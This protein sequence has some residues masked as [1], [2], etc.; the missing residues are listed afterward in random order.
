MNKVFILF[1]TI[2]FLIFT[3]ATYATYDPKSTPNNI[4]G[5]HI[6]FTYEV[7]KASEL[8][9]SSGGDWGYVTIPIQYDDRDI[10]KWQDFLNSCGNNHVIPILRIATGAYYKNTSVWRKPSNFDILDF[11]NFLNSL[12]W[13][14]KN[15][16]VLLFNETNRFDEWGGE[17][18]SPSEYADFVSFASVTFKA[19]S[20]DFYIIAGGL[21]NASPNDGH[22]YLDNFV[23]L[24]KV[25]EHNPKV[26]DNVDGL[27]SHSYPNPNFSQ[28]PSFDKEEGTSTYKYE[29]GL[30]ENL[31]G[32][33]LPVFITETGWNQDVLS[34]KTISEYYKT[35]MIDLWGKDP[36]VIAVTPFVLESSGGPFDKFSFLKNG[37]FSDSAKTYK[38]LPKI[39][40]SPFLNSLAVNSKNKPLAVSHEAKFVKASFVPDMSIDSKVLKDYFKMILGIK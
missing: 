9:N 26:F 33:S 16:Y 10:E 32:K 22:K 25:I 14:T 3:K 8:V 1:L 15:R 39:K 13:P 4:F 29:A 23:Y 12:S 40:G 21:D 27:A 38:L 35:S 24:R 36:R 20:S 18:P 5:I 2:V 6:L 34:Q 31:T 17:P 11:A 28:S 30:I 7:P 37:G 19:K